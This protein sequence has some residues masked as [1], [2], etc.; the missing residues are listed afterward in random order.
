MWE[1]AP[2]LAVP[3]QAPLFDVEAELERALTWLQNIEPHEFLTQMIAVLL[4]GPC[5]FRCFAVSLF[6]CFAVSLFRCFAVSLFRC[7]AVSLFRCF[8]AAELAR[9]FDKFGERV[10]NWNELPYWGEWLRAAKRWPAEAEAAQQ[11]LVDAT[12][13]LET[14]FGRKLALRRS[15]RDNSLCEELLAHGEAD[16][17]ERLDAVRC[18]EGYD[19]DQQ[20]ALEHPDALEYIYTYACSSL[21]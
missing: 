21:L 8:L 12:A 11:K 19:V 3:Q 2:S 13:T 9:M 17:G 1:K 15:L 14:F 16:V 20:R 7:F 5:M 6:R 18:F 10:N 4:S